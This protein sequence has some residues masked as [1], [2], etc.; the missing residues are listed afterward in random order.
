M[1]GLNFGGKRVFGRKL[2]AIALSVSFASASIVAQQTISVPGNQPTIQAGIDAATNGDTV[3]V[4]PGTYKENIDFK[5][6]A[7]TVISSGGPAATIIDGSR[8]G[9][10]VSFVSGETRS[11]QISGFTIENAGSSLYP[12]STTGTFAGVMVGYTAACFDCI[13]NPTITNNVITQNYGYGIEVYFGGAL[14]SGN[15]I[16]YTSTE[17]APAGDFGCDYDDGDGIWV[18]GT[19]NDPSVTTTISNNLIEHNLGHCFGGGIGFLAASGTITNNTIRYNQSLG[20]GGGISLGSAVIVQNLIYG[21]IAG[22]A[23]GGITLA[24]GGS[25][26]NNTIVGNTISRNTNI[27]DA[28][29]DG[30]QIA[31]GGDLSGTEFSNNIIVAGDSYGAIACDPSRQYESPTPLL[32]DHS[33]VL[34]FAGPAF[35]GWCVVPPTTTNAMISADPQF[36]SSGTEPFRSGDNSPTIGS[37]NPAVANLPAQDIDGNPRVQNGAVDMGVYEG[38]S[39]GPTNPAPDYKVALTPTSVTVLPGEAADTTITVSPAGGFIGAVSFTC[40]QTPA[41]VYCGFGPAGLLTGGVAIGGDNASVSTVLTLVNLS[42]A[43]ARRAGL[44]GEGVAHLKRDLAPPCLICLVICI[45]GILYLRRNA[46]RRFCL[47]PVLLLAGMTSCG[48]NGGGSYSPPPPPPPPDTA[49]VVISVAA[50]GNT[51]DTAQTVS[52]T[53][54]FQ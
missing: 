34:N 36:L 48:G 50:T 31:F 47:A 23:G 33:D 52:L 4:A 39:I 7:I 53:V 20:G 45:S 26:I 30:S 19:P 22:T 35:S 42:P 8:G 6:K 27:G 29:V 5:G 13:S 38:P 37:G 46:P 25:L 43:R 14:I 2:F 41:N 12:N 10:V 40:G 18:Q 9:I 24:G 3:V 21:N 32:V 17:Y 16:S 54:K 44:I 15:T 51:I 28:Y 49:T 11:S 1:F